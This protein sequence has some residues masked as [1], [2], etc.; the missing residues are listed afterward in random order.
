MVTNRGLSRLG[1]RY[2]RPNNLRAALQSVTSGDLVRTVGPKA[3]NRAAQVPR[4]EIQ[5][6]VRA[7]STSVLHNPVREGF[8]KQTIQ[9][10]P[11][12]AR[13]EMPG[14]ATSKGNRISC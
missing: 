11:H 8:D 5:A 9:E 12:G 14:S 3:M 1:H 6:I 7:T 13:I 10:L 2:R 4:L